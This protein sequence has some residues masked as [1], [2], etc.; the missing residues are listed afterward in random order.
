MMM[1][2]TTVDEGRVLT[3]ADMTKPQALATFQDRGKLVG[4]ENVSVSNSRGGLKFENMMQVMEF[5]R[6]MALADIGVP[7]HLR[8]NPGACLRIAIQADAWGF[9]PFSV[10]DKSYNVGDR[11]S[12]E[13]QLV[14]AVVER[15][16]PLEGRL[17]PEWV[18]EVANG[19]RRCIITGRLIGEVQ[20]FV[21][22][23]P[24]IGKIKTKNSPEWANNPD[25]Q[26]FYHSSR[27]WARIYVPDVLLGVYTRDEIENS[28]LGPSRARD[29]SD[30]ASRIPSNPEN[31]FDSQGIA[32]TLARAQGEPG[33][34]PGQEDG[35]GPAPASE[36]PEPEQAPKRT[37]KPKAEAS[38][39]PA[40]G[41]GSAEGGWAPGQDPTTKDE[42][43]QYFDAWLEGTASKEGAE[44]RWERERTMRAELRVGVT[45]R[46]AMERKL[47]EKFS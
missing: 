29:V 42:Y 45:E 2:D 16:A 25:K 9:D 5:A 15:R 43:R 6:M 19:T 47:N 31:G 14:H 41:E 24:E 23:G 26:L 36:A 4:A 37:R 33:P 38:S 18:G 46:K 13:S 28:E 10:A 12:Y 34:E 39:E 21:W 7:K 1:S 30:L 22:E 40:E 3:R 35:T 27:D 32:K 44:E 8:G 17:R 20:P 11:I